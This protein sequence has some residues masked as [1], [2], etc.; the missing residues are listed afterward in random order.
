[1]TWNCPDWAAPL[2]ELQVLL[3]PRR[4]TDRQ[5]DTVLRYCYTS[6]AVPKAER[7]HILKYKRIRIKR[8]FQMQMSSV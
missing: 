3:V 1:L 5:T 7:S 8:C 6:A 2:P 4:H